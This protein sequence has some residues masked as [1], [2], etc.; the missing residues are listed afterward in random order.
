MMVA[1]QSIERRPTVKEQQE[2]I[3]LQLQLKRLLLGYVETVFGFACS[4]KH[5][6]FDIL[7]CRIPA[8]YT[9][10]QP[11]CSDDSAQYGPLDA[12]YLVRAIAYT[13][14]EKREFAL[15]AESSQA[16]RFSIHAL[17][18]FVRDMETRMASM[19]H[20]M[21]VGERRAR[22]M[23]CEKS[24]VGGTV[25]SSEVSTPAMEVSDAAFAAF[26]NGGDL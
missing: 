20:M 6:G 1:T 4:A 14:A 21:S 26:M 12:Y 15:L 16:F 7:L 19:S 11:Y 2:M 9:H 23:E 24:R 10:M 22:F 18:G 8:D 13:D 17:Q 5:Y 3:E 25:Q